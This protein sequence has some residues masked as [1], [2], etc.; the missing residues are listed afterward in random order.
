MTRVWA[1]VVRRKGDAGAAVSPGDWAQENW[2]REKT[3]SSGR[4]SF[5]MWRLLLFEDNVAERLY[6]KLMHFL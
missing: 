1:A 6:G 3:V 2:V 4:R 5:F